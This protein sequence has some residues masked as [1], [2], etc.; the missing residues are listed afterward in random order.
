M[1]VGVCVFTYYSLPAGVLEL[2]H[3]LKECSSLYLKFS[4]KLAT[5][6]LQ[7]LMDCADKMVLHDCHRKIAIKRSIPN[8][9]VK[10]KMWQI[11]ILGFVKY[12]TLVL[13]LFFV[14]SCVFCFSEWV[15]IYLW[16]FYI[17]IYNLLICS[18]KLIFPYGFSHF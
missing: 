12:I 4:S 14:F 18:T 11:C 7:V 8:R 15:Y 10:V 5:L 6:T 16:V 2:Q 13:W 1:C 3:F 9:N 17:Y